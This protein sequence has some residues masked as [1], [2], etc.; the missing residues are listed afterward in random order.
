MFIMGFIFPFAWMIAAFLPLPENPVFV[1][2]ERNH[3]EL[4][5]SSDMARQMNPMEEARY[6]SAR[7]WRNLNRAMAVVG[8]VILILLIVLVLIGTRHQW[9]S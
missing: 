2:R 4:D 7:W 1:M 5:M 9:T 8:V 6:E 3:S